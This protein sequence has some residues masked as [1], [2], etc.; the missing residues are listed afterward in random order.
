MLNFLFG[1][2]FNVFDPYILDRTGNNS[3]LLGFV[4]SAAAVGG[5]VGGVLLSVWGG[6]KRRMTSVFLGEIMTGAAALLLFGLSGSLPFWILTAGIGALFFP[7]INGACQAIWQSKVPPDLQGRVF[8]ARRMIAMATMPVAPVIAGLLADYVT[9]P[10][11]TS[12]TWLS[13]AFG[14][15]VGTSA[16]SG[17][18]LQFVIAGVLY[19]AIVLG[20]LLFVPSVRNVEDLIP[21]HDE[22][23]T[24]DE[25]PDGA[26]A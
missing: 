16:G 15:L 26:L 23:E 1:L 8:S 17:K 5:V 13:R 9:E 2:A 7:L 25:V 4:R 6:F 3:V 21:D 10:A 19:L 18:A 20:F 11:M 14:G 12:A 22:G 24:D